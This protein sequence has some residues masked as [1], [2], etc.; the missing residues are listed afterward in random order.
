MIE[1]NIVCTQE[2]KARTPM[3]K[4]SPYACAMQYSKLD[5]K[6]SE[7]VVEGDV[8]EMFDTEYCV[9]RSAL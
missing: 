5:L 6:F 4:D 3:V 9:V 8:N 7:E 2:V 1:E